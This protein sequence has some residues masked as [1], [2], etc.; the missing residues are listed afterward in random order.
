MNKASQKIRAFIA[1]HPDPATVA[2]LGKVQETLREE[3]QS[4]AFRWV[5]DRLHLTLQFLGHLP[6]DR[7]SG[8]ERVMAEVCASHP[9]F[10]LRAR[11]IGCFPNPRRARVLWAG[12]DG[13]LDAL[14][15]LKNELDEKLATLGY[16]P[17]KRDYSPHL[18]LARVEHLALREIEQLERQLGCFEAV[19]FGAWRVEKVELMR[20][21]LSPTGAKYDLLKAISLKSQGASST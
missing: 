17:E 11:G 8:F 6:I 3:L 4:E 16:E 14:R 7:V 2:E 9:P 18:T 21:V 15:Q 20:S 13:D 5:G 10:Q 19:R 12:L 1:I